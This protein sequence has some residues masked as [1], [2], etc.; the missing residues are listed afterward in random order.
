MAVSINMFTSSTESP[1]L[2]ISSLF[3]FM[4][5]YFPPTMGSTYKSFTPSNPS[6]S[7][8]NCCANLLIV[9]MFCP[10]NLIPTSVLIPVDSMLIRLIMGCVHPFITPGI[11]SLAFNSLIISSLEKP[12]LHS[13]CGF[14][15]TM[16]SIIF[17]GAL[18]VAVF[19]RPAFPRTFCT[20]GTVIIS[21]SCTCMIRFIS[22]LETSGKVT[23]IKSSD[24]SSNGGINSVPRLSTRG[25]LPNTNAKLNARVVL[26]HFKH[27]RITGLYIQRKKRETGCLLS[28]RTSPFKNSVIS[29]GTR[30]TTTKAEP[31]IAKVLV[32]T[33]GENSLF[34][35]PVRNRIGLKD[36]NVISMEL[37]TAFPINL[38]DASIFFS[39]SSFDNIWFY[40]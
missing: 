24:P 4:S 3:I 12:S 34:S 7:F 14:N 32:Q 37:N 6:S 23:G 9:S 21:L 38:D 39:L 13:D 33:K 11:C 35:C 20:S 30:N 16:L 1:Y 40:L 22:E 19:A 29:T 15:S 26:F 17:I 27:Q 31:I 28:G 2:P 10:Y 25:T 8:L 5:M 18:S 36:T